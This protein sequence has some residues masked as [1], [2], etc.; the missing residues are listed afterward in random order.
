MCCQGNFGEVYSGRLRCDN[1]PVAVKACRENLAPEHKN[2]F[3]M[4]ARL[5]THTDTHIQPHT[6]MHAYTEMLTVMLFNCQQETLIGFL[7]RSG[8]GS[9][10]FI[11]LVS[12]PSF[13]LSLHPFPLTSRILKQYDHP[14]IVKLIGVCTQEQPI[15]IIMELVQGQCQ[16]W[17]PQTQQ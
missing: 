17:K 2:K 11:S 8:C 10:F 13:P 12:S 5:V 7:Y 9:P 14:N 1:T 3:L 15:Y 4:E 16:L 6:C